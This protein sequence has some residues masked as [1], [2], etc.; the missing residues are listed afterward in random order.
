MEDPP[1]ADCMR[2]THQDLR[3]C[4]QH[5]RVAAGQADGAVQAMVH[6]RRSLQMGGTCTTGQSGN[7]RQMPSL[8]INIGVPVAD[9]AL[10][11]Q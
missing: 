4:M 6:H 7:A 2:P 11:L 5:L 1:P 3:A 9:I 8:P 10:I